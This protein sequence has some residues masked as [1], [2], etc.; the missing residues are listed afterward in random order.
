MRKLAV[1][2]LLCVAGCSEQRSHTQH[3]ESTS[4]FIE[5]PL[6]AMRERI[7]D[8]A[9]SLTNEK[10]VYDP[11]YFTISYPGGDVPVDKGVCTDVVIRTFRKINLDLQKLVHEDMKKNWP[12]YP[13]LWGLPA[14]DRNIDHRR[15]PNLMEFFRRHGE[16]RNGGT[17]AAA[18]LPGDIVAWRLQN[19]RTHIGIVV[20]RSSDDGERK[21]VVHNIGAGQ[22]LE[23]CLFNFDVIGHYYFERQR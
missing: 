17:N 2:I 12:L 18:Y 19:G 5:T 4:S 16:V 10:V 13:K 21:L 1:F 7:S 8:A 23:D 20:N 6:S 9:L 22:V 3:A 15:V 11:S 14:P